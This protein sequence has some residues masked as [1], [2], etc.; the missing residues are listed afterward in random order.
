MTGPP[1]RPIV[2]PADFPAVLPAGWIVEKSLAITRVSRT[3]RVLADGRPAV[4]R[5]DETGARRLGLNRH[6]EPE[7]LRAVAEAGVGPACL[8]ADPDRGTLLTEWLPGQAWSA[9]DLR[10]PANLRR[11]ATLL[12]QVHGLPPAGPVLNLEAAITRYEVLGGPRASGPAQV[13]REQL[14]RCLAAEADGEAASLRLCHN[15]PTPGNF[16]AGPDGRLRLIDWEYAG[17]GP[18]AFDLAGL[19]VGAALDESGDEIL[20]AAYRS[21]QSQPAELAGHLAGQ[22]ARHRAWKAFCQALGALWTE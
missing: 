6:A 7:V 5:V 19:A 12:R 2:L 18:V 10:E 22:L 9:A 4:L 8:A 3:W 13:A 21:P 11:A 20:L 15:D 17:V 1:L 16:I 14:A